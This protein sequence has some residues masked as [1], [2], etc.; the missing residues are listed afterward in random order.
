MT[1]SRASLVLAAAAL[2][3]A[4]VLLMLEPTLLK[5][6]G[7][8]LALLAI[9]GLMVV[10]LVSAKRQQWALLRSIRRLETQLKHTDDRLS[11]VEYRTQPL[12][13]IKGSVVKTSAESHEALLHLRDL[14][15]N[16]M[17]AAPAV[18]ET[19]FG[20]QS[21]SK[22]ASV[23]APGTIR[24]SSIERRPSAHVPGRDAAR[25]EMDVTSERNLARLLS[26]DDD[27]MHIELAF[28]GSSLVRERLSSICSVTAVHPGMG[29][30][31]LSSSTSYL[32]IS[33]DDLDSTSWRGCL[34]ASGTRLYDELQ[35][36]L[37]NARGRGIAVVLHG[38]TVPSHFTAELE[39][40]A[41][42]VVG[43]DGRA[44]TPWGSD[45]D[46]PVLSALRSTAEAQ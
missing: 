7:L 16:G 35:G 21:G 3:V 2:L 26:A 46:S 20:S 4:T 15:D 44:E 23:Y 32:I 43:P 18:G 17:A 9:A 34:D 8:A 5:S 25:Q 1:K 45:I 19:H 31:A 22:A 13:D 10:A 6:I 39:R 24:A 41:H 12:H 40:Q 30:A 42:V 27:Q 38:S 33:L 37:A 11:R 28:V 14:V 36:V 29:S